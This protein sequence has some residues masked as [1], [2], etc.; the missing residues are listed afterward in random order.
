MRAHA[1]AH[2]DTAIR[3]ALDGAGHAALAKALFHEEAFLSWR[4]VIYRTKHREP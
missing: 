3:Q 1:V 2:L 4:E